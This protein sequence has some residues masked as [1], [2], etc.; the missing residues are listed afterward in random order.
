[1]EKKEI[2]I[3]NKMKNINNYPDFYKGIGKL[4]NHSIEI[5]K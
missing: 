1:M 2:E 4:I 5:Q 3:I